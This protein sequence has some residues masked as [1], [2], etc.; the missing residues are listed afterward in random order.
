RIERD[1]RSGRRGRGGIRA[2]STA[3]STAATGSAN[4]ERHLDDGD[5]MPGLCMHAR[6]GGTDVEIDV[7]EILLP[8][9][10]EHLPAALRLHEVHPRWKAPRHPAIE[11]SVA[12][13]RCGRRTASRGHTCAVCRRAAPAT[14]SATATTTTTIGR[15]NRVH[16]H[17]ELFRLELH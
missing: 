4:A 1:L 10:D 13:W 8:G 3:T 2:A 14:T 15:E 7:L 11:L 17:A 12:R 9:G 5:R 16:V 6:V